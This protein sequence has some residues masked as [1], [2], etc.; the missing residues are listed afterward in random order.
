MALP[1][2]YQRICMIMKVKWDYNIFCQLKPYLLL[3]HSIALP[4]K[5]ILFKGRR[6]NTSLFLITSRQ[7]LLQATQNTETSRQKLLQGARNTETSRRKLLQGARNTETS[8]RKLLQ[9][10]RNTETS[11]RK[12][13]QGARN[14]ETSKRKLLQRR[15]KLLQGR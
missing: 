9:G 10:A 12:L 13:L 14:T 15:Q 8:R 4:Q 6:C 5:R 1:C 2:P 3:R 11:R 7:K